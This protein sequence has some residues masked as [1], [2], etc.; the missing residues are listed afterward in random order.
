MAIHA[1]H[2]AQ[3]MARGKY[4]QSAP[5]KQSASYDEI[6]RRLKS[7]NLQLVTKPDL[8]HLA[9]AEEREG[10]SRGVQYFKFADDEAFQFTRRGGVFRNAVKA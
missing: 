5:E 8:E 2:F 6:V 7:K 4:L 9:R 10:R 3:R 1:K